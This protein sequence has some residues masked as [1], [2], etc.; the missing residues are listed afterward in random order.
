M[1]NIF[2]WF[3]IKIAVLIMTSILLLI[4]ETGAVPFEEW[5]KTFGGT[6]DDEFRYVKQTSDN[7]F[8]LIGFTDSYGAGGSDAW[9]VKTDSQGKEQWNRTFGGLN[10]EK[11]YSGQQTSDGGFVLVG[12]KWSSYNKVDAWL[13]KTDAFGIKQWDKIFNGYNLSYSVQQTSDGGYVFVGIIAKGEWVRIEGQ[14]SPGIPH[15]G[16]VSRNDVFLIKTDAKGNLLWNRTFGGPKEEGIGYVQQTSDG[17]Y[18]LA[19]Y[20]FSF[21]T[22]NNDAWLIKTNMNGNEQWNKT[23]KGI[24]FGTDNAVRQTSDGGYILALRSPLGGTISRPVWIIKI[25]VIGN[26]LWNKTLGTYDD[27]WIK[28]VQQTSDGGYIFAGTVFFMDRYLDS[29][30]V[31][32]WLVKTDPNG[33]ELWNKSI[34]GNYYD[35]ANFIQQTS[36]GGYIVAGRKDAPGGY[37]AWLVKTSGETSEIAEVPAAIPIGTLTISPTITPT[38]TLTV[39]GTPPVSSREKASGFDIVLAMTIL[40]LAIIIRRRRMNT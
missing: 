27:Y 16:Y 31:N 40:L 25:D 22:E 26:V 34:G 29:Y 11:A 24:N 23:F 2:R 14:S 33:N 30:N 10:N 38:P 7:G 1:D 36:D 17:G 37:D 28:S 35:I 4:A 21:G 5:N 6:G 8:I 3:A 32:A 18:M 19:G 39:V 13:I 20:T 15:V 9:L 12:F